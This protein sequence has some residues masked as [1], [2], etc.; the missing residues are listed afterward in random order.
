MNDTPRT[1]MP[2]ATPPAAEATG[3]EL[4]SPASTFGDGTTPPVMGPIPIGTVVTPDS[5]TLL[6]GA[7]GLG[8]AIRFAFA[9][10]ACGIIGP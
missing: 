4:G 7:I 1:C 10:A 6:L 5:D 8:L 2:G 9:F 3:E